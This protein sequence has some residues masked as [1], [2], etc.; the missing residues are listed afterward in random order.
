MLIL[1][2]TGALALTG[3]FARLATAEDP[4]AVC[5]VSGAAAKTGPTDAW[6]HVNGQSVSFCCNNCPKAFAADP[7]KF[8][9]KMALK[10]PVMKTNAIAKPDKKLRAAV[11]NGYVYFCC[12]GCPAAFAK[13][14]HKYIAELRDPVSGETFKLAANS[15][16]VAYKGGHFL[17]AN[18]ENKAKFEADPAKYA[19]VVGG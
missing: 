14:P 7:E 5:P 9:A 15:P 1:L 11:N 4:K 13:E 2:A 17:F 8:A 12:A 18:A 16:H 19:L 6:T 3:A 10:C